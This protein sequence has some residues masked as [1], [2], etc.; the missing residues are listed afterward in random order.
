MNNKGFEGGHF[1]SV[2]IAGFA[3]LA[4]LAV[5]TNMWAAT[6]GSKIS[7]PTE[8]TFDDMVKAIDSLSEDKTTADFLFRAEEKE[9]ILCKS[10]DDNK[11]EIFTPW[12]KSNKHLDFRNVYP[13]CYGKA[14]ICAWADDDFEKKPYKCEIISNYNSFTFAGSEDIRMGSDKGIIFKGGVVKSMTV[15]K[16][17]VSIVFET[18]N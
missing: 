11:I 1:I 12:Y 15:R 5:G 9:F 14:C 6:F 18:K 10:V 16:Q 8:Y 17:G 4:V 3:I 7:P 13:V 2:L